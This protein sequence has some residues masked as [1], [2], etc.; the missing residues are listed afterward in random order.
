MGLFFFGK[1]ED[2]MAKIKDG[3]W[4]AKPLHLFLH[5]FSTCFLREKLL[6]RSREGIPAAYGN[7]APLSRQKPC[8]VFFVPRDGVDDDEGKA[9]GE[10][11]A[12][13]KTAGLRDEEIGGIH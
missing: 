12:R 9:T 13:G 8:I 11:L 7:G 1:R 2:L 5:R 10:R 6:D 3:V 4:L